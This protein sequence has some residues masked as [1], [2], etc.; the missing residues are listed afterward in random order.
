MAF[1]EALS[2]RHLP[3]VNVKSVA[4]LQPQFSKTWQFTLLQPWITDRFILTLHNN[5][6]FVL[7]PEEGKIIGTLSLQCSIS[8]LAASG[9][10]IFLIYQATTTLRKIVKLSIHPALVKLRSS[11]VLNAGRFAGNLSAASS[12]AGSREGLDLIQ[13]DKSEGRAS[14]FLGRTGVKKGRIRTNEGDKSHFEEKS[15]LV[16]R[17]NTC[18]ESLRESGGEKD[19]RKVELPKTDSTV[20]EENSESVETGEVLSKGMID[21][22]GV[23]VEDM[24][25][26]VER[27]NED[28]V[29]SAKCDSEKKSLEAERSTVVDVSQTESEQ[30]AAKTT[31]GYESKI[32]EQAEKQTSVDAITVIPTDNSSKLAKAEVSKE[33]PTKKELE[34]EKD[35]SSIS[36]HSRGKSIIPSQA[37]AQG[38]SHVKADLK[39]IKG[40]L[41]LGKL[42]E[43]LSQAKHHSPTSQRKHEQHTTYSVSNDIVKLSTDG[44]SVDQDVQV[45]SPTHVA[46]PTVDP[47]EQRRRLR[48]AEIVERDDEDVVVATKTQTKTRKTR[49]RKTKKSSKHSSAASESVFVV[50]TACT[51]N[52]WMCSV[53]CLFKTIAVIIF[54]QDI[55]CTCTC[56][57]HL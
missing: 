56:M 3:T 48:M 14:P 23:V 39:E 12:R 6:L 2:T 41:K 42:T 16:C 54:P 51:C 4:S 33:S 53:V 31:Q 50:K 25:A 15:T 32:M 35:S 57:K 27:R 8:A 30:V 37:L 10:H 18:E 20:A 7:D 55:H 29:K 49:K 45:T 36:E 17:N 52:W 46:T 40:A 5:T 43:F 34:P 26:S 1:K 38:I 9:G 24:A 11:P 13:T 19:S 21:N 28:E 22:R 47:E 44:P